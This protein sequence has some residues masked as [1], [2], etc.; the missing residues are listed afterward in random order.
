MWVSLSWPWYRMKILMY[1]TGPLIGEESGVWLT[2]F[3]K[4]SN[5]GTAAP[6]Y[7]K[8]G[9]KL[10]TGISTLSR[11]RDACLESPV[12]RLYNNLNISIKSD[13]SVTL[14]HV[15]SAGSFSQMTCCWILKSLKRLFYCKA[16]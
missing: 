5:I 12:L 7:L 6:A 16:Q 1:I 4:G 11:N 2:G 10:C 13:T 14:R 15:F 3:T 8:L 9:I